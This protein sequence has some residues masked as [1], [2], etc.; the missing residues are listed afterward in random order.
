MMYVGYS[1]EIYLTQWVVLFYHTG[2]TK[3]TNSHC[4]QT[5]YGG[6]ATEIHKS[7]VVFAGIKSERFLYSKNTKMPFNPTASWRI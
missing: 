1:D 3:R 2:K 5:T 4:I 7:L 6:G